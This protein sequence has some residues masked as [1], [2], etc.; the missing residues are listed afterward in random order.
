M[1]RIADNSQ[2]GLF[3]ILFLSKEIGEMKMLSQE[4]LQVGVSS[5]VCHDLCESEI[6][7]AWVFES[8]G[9]EIGQD[10]DD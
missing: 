3:S 4:G 2:S 9:E 5:Y 10:L 6:R 1:E 8:H 7:K